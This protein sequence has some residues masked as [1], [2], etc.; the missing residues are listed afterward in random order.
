MSCV[1]K[2]KFHF[3]IVK[4]H[5]FIV[6]VFFLSL[7]RAHLRTQIITTIMKNLTVGHRGICLN[8]TAKINNAW[9]A[10]THAVDGFSAIEVF[11]CGTNLNFKRKKKKKKRG[12][13]FLK[14]LFFFF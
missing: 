13:F 9:S 10:G 1:K 14:K 3:F 6:I 12:F 2:I 5:F 8:S 7:S 11:R 4:F